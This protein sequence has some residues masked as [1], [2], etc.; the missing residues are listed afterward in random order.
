MATR[1]YFENTNFTTF[2]P[3]FSGFWAYTSEAGRY[4]LV[5]YKS[6]NP[7]ITGTTIGPTWNGAGL[8]R[9]YITEPLSAQ[10]INGTVTG[11]LMVREYNPGDNVNRL[12]T[13]IKAIDGS[14]NLRGRVLTTGNYSNTTT[15]FVNNVSHR[16]KI[17]AT[18][19]SLTSV[20]IQSGDR[21][22]IELGYTEAAGA[23]PE[24]S[25]LWG[26]LTSLADLPADE[27]QTTLGIPFIEFS[28]DVVRLKA[29]T[30]NGLAK[31]VAQKR[32]EQTGLAAIINLRSN[33]QT[34]L[35]RIFNTLRNG[36]TGIARILN[37][38][39]RSQTGVARI[40]LSKNN[41]QTGIARIFNTLRNG[42]TGRAR[43]LTSSLQYQTGVARIFNT[44]RFSISGKASI[45][46]DTTTIQ[47]HQTGKARIFNTIRNYQTGVAR[48]FNTLRNGQTG[49]ARILVSKNNYQTG[50]ARIFNTLRKEQT[51]KGFI[52]PNL[53]ASVSWIRFE[54][55]AGNST[56]NNQTGV[57]RIFK[58]L[59]NSLNGIARI[60]KTIQQT[61]TGRARIV[62]R[63]TN[64]QTG[65][66]RIKVTR[67]ESGGWWYWGRDIPG[68]NYVRANS[69]QDAL[70]KQQALAD[71]ASDIYWTTENPNGAIDLS[72]IYIQK[73]YPLFPINHQEYYEIEVYNDEEGVEYHYLFNS[74][75]DIYPRLLDIY[76]SHWLFA[77]AFFPVQYG[78][79]SIRSPFKAYPI[80]DINSGTWNTTPLY[81]KI[82][83]ETPVT[84]DY[85]ICSQNPNND[86]CEMLLSPLMSGH[87]SSLK[88]NYV[89]KKQETNFYQIN[90]TVQLFEGAVKKH[91]TILP[92]ISGLWTTGSVSLTAHEIKSITNFS[93]LRVKFVANRV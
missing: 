10:T 39:Q 75:N 77:G 41:Y 34:G 2:S 37:T 65:V 73:Y 52:V 49:V 47:N 87:Y 38:S 69:F 21:L 27:T 81:S 79:A 28:I 66:A 83:E 89:Y 6:N 86:T 59:Q 74:V 67:K 53:T 90:L 25:A 36:Q 61:Q 78:K 42:Q 70:E 57:A 54:F 9:Q 62:F 63:Y 16:N 88:L 20:A 80:Q 17:I 32:Q 3:Q 91:E 14:G 26:S 43:I 45:D 44:V 24:A 82:W 18:N 8:D 64:T 93:D 33:S 50:I 40:L 22:V 13:C 58:A 30:Q 12:V 48:I 46:T 19:T 51:G 15:E 55:P 85:I 56:T 1:F 31:I 60:F 29:R 11:Q 4:N 71:E 68:G 84:N 92:L 23:T 5:D 72:Y 7:L 35:A 76:G